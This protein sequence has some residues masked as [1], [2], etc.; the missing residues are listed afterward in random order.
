M[1]LHREQGVGGAYHAFG[2]VLGEGALA[3]V[4]EDL[5]ELHAIRGQNVLGPRHAVRH[6]CVLQS[7]RKHTHQ[8]ARASGTHIDTCR[9]LSSRSA[10]DSFFPS[11]DVSAASWSV[12]SFV[13]L[14]NSSSSHSISSAICR[15]A[16]PSTARPL[17]PL[18]CCGLPQ[19]RG[20]AC[21]ALSLRTC[22]LD[23]LAGAKAKGAL[24]PL[25]REK[26]QDA[27]AEGSKV[28]GFFT[29]AFV[30]AL[31]VLM[32]VMLATTPLPEWMDGS[33]DEGPTIGG[34][35][36]HQQ[37]VRMPWTFENGRGPAADE[38]EGE[39]EADEDGQRPTVGYG[40]RTAASSEPG[41][42]GIHGTPHRGPPPCVVSLER[43]H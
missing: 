40:S 43:P 13:R 10:L 11:R 24:R 5:A 33:G 22:L 36:I 25:A 41:T 7:S 42:Y 3:N 39:G 37:E 30:G 35:L 2:I 12:S 16:H 20:R 4:L 31:L 9:T 34:P 6:E 17:V 19:P 15:A 27:M 29:Y 28:Q 26:K 8:I 38:D 18:P 1:G 32:M 23:R 14:H 21:G